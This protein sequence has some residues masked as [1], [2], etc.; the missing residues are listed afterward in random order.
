MY[1][2]LPDQNVHSPVIPQLDHS[3]FP[4]LADDD[5]PGTLPL[6]CD[7]HHLLDLEFDE[8]TSWLA[9]RGHPR[10]RAAQIRKWIVESPR[11]GFDGMSDLPKKLRAELGEAFVFWTMTEAARQESEDGTQKLLLGL[12]DGDRIE[13]VLLRDDRGHRTVCI[14]TQVGCAMG[15]VFCASGLDGV[16][17][18]LTSGEI[19]EQVLRFKSLLPAEERLSHVV[20]MGVGEPLANLEAMLRA[21]RVV[22]SPDGLGISA[23]RVTISTVGL[24]PAI[25]RLA[26]SG[27]QYHLAVSLHAPDDQLRNEIVPA[28]RKVGI[29]SILE[30]TDDYFATTGR[31]VT[32][33]YVLLAD[34]NDGDQH[35]RQ[36]ASLLK[37]RPSLVNLIPYNPVAGLSYQTPS[38]ER[39]ARFVAILESAGLAVK[40]R[41]RKGDRIDAAC[42]QL[43]RSRA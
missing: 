30:A 4:P 36:L 42:G 23:R 39:T 7:M 9:D 10:Y 14:S 18:N 33:E 6:R 22:T 31:R 24:P 38:P 25:R 27:V 41:Y 32:F 8:L 37:G 21:L 11:T 1:F 15:C 20:V 17:R 19:L 3:T 12:H 43:R 35:A 29:Q 40:T 34:V 5:R 28:N 13:C 16:R 26:E 2:S